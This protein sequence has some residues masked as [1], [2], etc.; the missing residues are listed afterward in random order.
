MAFVVANAGEMHVLRRLFPREMLVSSLLAIGVAWAVAGATAQ[1][2][3]AAAADTRS[4]GAALSLDAARAAFAAGRLDEALALLTDVDAPGLQGRI[5]E[6]RGDA[7]GA[8]ALYLKD[9]S[10]P[11]AAGRAPGATLRAARCLSAAREGPK[12]IGAALAAW[13]EV[14]A[15]LLG[16]D[17]LV[18]DEI[19]TF[20][21][22]NDLPA[23]SLAK[24]LDLAVATFDD[25]RRAALAH[26]L[27]VLAEREPAL[28]PR[29]LERLFV[30]LSDTAAAARARSLPAARSRPPEDLAAALKRATALADRHE[31]AAVIAALEPFGL[32]GKADPGLACEARLLLGKA[33]RKLRKYAAAQK[34]LELV[35]TR[36]G[37][38]WKKRAQYLGARVASLSKSPGSAVILRAFADR[39]PTD[40]LT[41][42]VLLWLGEVKDAQGDHAG[43]EEAWRRARDTLPE[44]DMAHEVRWRLAWSRARQGD[45]EGARALLDEAARK[46]GGRVD[47]ADRAVYWRARLG[48]CP[49]LDSLDAGA[50]GA[51]ADTRG[52]ALAELVAFADS[53]PASFYGHLARLLAKDVAARWQLPAPA[54]PAL[55]GLRAAAAAG[56]IRPSPALAQDPRFLLAVELVGGG[57]D[58]EALLVLSDVDVARASAADRF[59]VAAWMGRAGAPGA[60]HALLRDG[61][62]ALLPGR[63]STDSALAWALGWPRAH[64]WALE[65]AA[66]QHGV[67]RPL[68]FGLAREESAFDADVV[69]WAGAVGLCQLMTFTAADEAKALKLAVPD[70]DALKDPALNARLG[71]AHLGRR[72]KGMRHPMLAIAAYNAGPGGVAKWRPRGPLDT[73]VEQIP[74]DETRNYVKKVTG[75]WVTYAALDGTIEDVRFPLV[76][77]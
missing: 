6:A 29:A 64:A 2:A 8:C 67:P 32:D 25:E 17:A 38:D 41:D 70:V 15:G 14:S 62:L 4:L 68:L 21:E 39:W 40:P 22:A 34:Q 72:L 24:A 48:L 7:A 53:R 42:D 69:S 52:A 12:T 5:L 49:R 33:W 75:S 66:D 11:A 76:I 63:P 35:A 3:P 28:A 37:D 10:S 51:D 59:V 47:V 60:G 20:V 71:A 61:G 26:T 44:G 27:V 45:V 1:A 57:Y 18:L 54:L 56:T 43:A 74:V 13:T 36:C 30:E 31:S 73:W 55:A 9:R 58:D 23:T 77:R 46:A 50:C 19:A 16:H 65:P